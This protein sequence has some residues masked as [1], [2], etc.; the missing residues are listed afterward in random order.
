[1]TAD[2]GRRTFLRTA[3]AATGALLVGGCASAEG[4]G[5]ARYYADGKDDRPDEGVSPAEDLMREHGV[6]NRALLVY[7]EGV[8]R[9]DVDE[10][11]DAHVIARGATLVRRFVE[12]YHERLEEDHVFPR[13]E[14]AGRHVELVRVLR[15][16]HDAGRRETDRILGLAARAIS[17]DPTGRSD[18]AAS[19][20]A[21]VRMFRPHEAREDTVLFPA[22]RETVGD[23]EWRLLGERFEEEEHAKFGEHGFEDAVEQIA[24]LE[25]AFEI[26]D[27]AKFTIRVA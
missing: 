12:N 11:C 9:L 8:R 18:L 7:E 21:Y 25:R 14:R 1:M 27:L 13:L 15:E 26:H 22:L 5:S 17:D 23:R 16:Q 6:L 10:S 20:R 19:L 24:E 2:L 3:A 4:D